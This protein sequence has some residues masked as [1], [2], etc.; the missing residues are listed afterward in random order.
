MMWSGFFDLSTIT[1]EGVL[2]E[3][4]LDALELSTGS[5]VD[6]IPNEW[7]R[8]RHPTLTAIDYINDY[9]ST[10]HYNV[11]IDRYVQHPTE[12]GRYG[13]IGSSTFNGGESLY[14]FIYVELETLYDLVKKYELKKRSI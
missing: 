10:K 12:Y 11:L 1:D 6:Y 2:K 14:L 13:E 3:L 4:F 7:G 8:E 5:H 9:L